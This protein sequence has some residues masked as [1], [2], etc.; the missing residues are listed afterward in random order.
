MSYLVVVIKADGAVSS[1]SQPK[2]PTL[3]QLQKLVGGLIQEV[4][5][6]TRYGEHKRGTAYA[7]EE[8]LMRGSRY[9]TKATEAWLVCLHERGGVLARVP[10]LVGDVVFVCRE[11]K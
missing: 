7:D 8:G 2:A 6:F 11:G 4:P 1:S 9:N 3:G 5:H 10:R